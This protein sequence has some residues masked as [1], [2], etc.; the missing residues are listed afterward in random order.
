MFNLGYNRPSHMK[1]RTLFVFLGWV[2]IGFLR[3]EPTENIPLYDLAYCLREAQSRNPGLILAQDDL[4]ISRARSWVAH[5]SLWPALTAK[6]DET[7]GLANDGT[8][9]PAFLQRSYG[10]QVTQTLF[11]GGRVIATQKQASLN[12]QVARLQMDKQQLELRHAVTEAY[13]RVV[14]L[15]KSLAIHRQTHQELQDDLEKAVR[16]ELSASRS[17]RIELLATRAQNRESESALAE[18]EEELLQARMALM[19][20]IGQRNQTPFRVP[21]EIPNGKIAVSEEE[22]LRV[23]RSHRVELKIAEKLMRSA[24]LTRTLGRSG[25]YPKVDLNGFYGRSGSAYIETEPFGLRTDWN[26]GVSVAWPIFGNTVKFS[27]FKEHTSP[28]L[29]ESSRTETESQSLT[30]TLGDA[31]GTVVTHRE[32]KKA[33]HEEEW[34]YDKTER[35]LENEVRLA[36]F[37]VGAARRRLEAAQAKNEEA[38]QSFKDTRNLFSDDRAHLGDLA[39]ARN[40]VAFAEAGLAQARAN[41]LVAL[42]G[43]NRAIGAPDYFRI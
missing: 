38:A 28:R 21:E 5:M 24:R 40:R 14:A 9:T 31:L 10:L 17:A 1:K 7:R 3:A 25:F 34:R 32:N 33:Y 26:A 11:A 22:A 13:W 2:A 23:A 29:G 41:Y 27:G 39:G 12:A 30:F 18:T 15:E 6:A 8:Q 19:D 43:L 35:D 16:H 4:A 37:R 42:S 20:A 36:L